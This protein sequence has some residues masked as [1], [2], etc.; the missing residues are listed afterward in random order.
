MSACVR[1]VLLCLAL[2]CVATP[3]LGYVKVLTWDTSADRVLDI[4][5]VMENAPAHATFALLEQRVTRVVEEVAETEPDLVLL[6]NVAKYTEIFEGIEQDVE[7]V[8]HDTA[9]QLLDALA[10]AELSYTAAHVL[11]L[12]EAVGQ[13]ASVLRPGETSGVRV[14]WTNVVLV[15]TSEIGKVD[16]SG[17]SAALYSATSTYD[18]EVEDYVGRVSIE[19]VPVYSGYQRVPFTKEG[20]RWMVT[21]TRLDAHSTELSDEQLAEVLAATAHD[22]N[23]ILAGTF[24]NVIGVQ[25]DEDDV[26][27]A[28]Y[29]S[30]LDQRF[31]DLAFFLRNHEDNTC[32]IDVS[33]PTSSASSRQDFIFVRSSSERVV[34]HAFDVVSADVTATAH[35]GVYGSIGA[36]RRGPGPF[37]ADP[38]TPPQPILIQTFSVPS[39]SILMVDDDESDTES[40]PLVT[41][42]TPGDDGDGTFFATGPLSPTTPEDD[43]DRRVSPTTPLRTSDGSV[44]TDGITFSAGS[45]LAMSLVAAA[46]FALIC[47]AL[48]GGH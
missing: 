41:P 9:A 43:E 25:D 44:I 48:V 24:S 3:A 6:Y 26:P 14:V 29:Q 39:S 1:A 32:C 11:S 42:T 38:V 13:G 36:P 28:A 23:A 45:R 4:P 31:Q 20:K 10:A 21:A 34:D 15:K 22:A 5:A 7:L 46:A 27:S 40:N 33:S 16:L 37:M 8:A 12:N 19:Q 35:Y 2:A 18:V 17:A 47:T 30:V